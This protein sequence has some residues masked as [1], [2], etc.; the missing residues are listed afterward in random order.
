MG[1]RC[2]CVST[3]LPRPLTKE[4]LIDILFVMK[5][6]AA[7]LPGIDKTQDAKANQVTFLVEQNQANKNRYRFS[8]Y[9]NGKLVR[10]VDWE[11]IGH[12]AMNFDEADDILRDCFGVK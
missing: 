1:R 5:N 12:C 10:T 11:P 2:T 6:K 4:K 7:M 8:A 3:V 9:H